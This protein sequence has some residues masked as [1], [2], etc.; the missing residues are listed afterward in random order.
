MREHVFGQIVAHSKSTIALIAKV[1]F[2]L[3]MHGHVDFELALRSKLAFAHL[4]RE[5]VHRFVALLVNVQRRIGGEFLQAQTALEH[6]LDI[7]QMH[8]AYVIGDDAFATEK[9]AANV[10]FVVFYFL[11]EV[12]DVIAQT[13]VVGK[14]FVTFRTVCR[15]FRFRQM[16]LFA[17]AVVI[18][19][20]FGRSLCRFLW[21][22]FLGSLGDI[23]CCTC[24]RR[25]T[26]T[27]R[28][29]RCIIGIRF[30]GS[31]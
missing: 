19:C 10:A 4:A 30:F 16:I 11:V 23:V 3:R 1:V 18:R 24:G 26:S 12:I 6:L 13:A 27:S 21:R 22:L 2:L 29:G 15:T 8:A 5:F 14:C 17:A 9:C 20:G 7:F 28:N 31:I 25:S